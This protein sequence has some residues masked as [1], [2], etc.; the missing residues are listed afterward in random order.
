MDKNLKLY[1]KIDEFTWYMDSNNNYYGYDYVGQLMYKIE[2]LK[3]GNWKLYCNGLS[4]LYLFSN[5]KEDL[6]LNVSL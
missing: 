3:D 2:L 4:G 5:R 1:M 6:M